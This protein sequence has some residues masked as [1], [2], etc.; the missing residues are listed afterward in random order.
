MNSKR[1]SGRSHV[2]GHPTPWG[3]SP[4]DSSIIHPHRQ[5]AR[6]PGHPARRAHR[7]PTGHAGSRRCQVRMRRHATRTGGRTTGAS[8]CDT[9]GQP[10]LAA[11]TPRELTPAWKW[12]A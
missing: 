8:I 4:H 2:P 9:D 11:I 3:C 1:G 10:W 6:G 12:W 5:Q 7:G